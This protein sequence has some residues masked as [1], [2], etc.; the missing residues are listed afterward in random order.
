[1]KSCQ[2]CLFDSLKSLWECGFHLREGD[3]NT[4]LFH[5]HARHRRKNFI[6]KILDG[7]QVL[8]THEDKERVIYNFYN[9]LLGTSVHRERTINLDELNIASHH[10]IFPVWKSLFLKRFGEPSLICLLTKPQAPMVLQVSFIKCAGQL[11]K[12]TSWLRSQLS[13]AEDLE[14]SSSSIQPI[15]HFC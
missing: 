6:G 15:S 2:F 8:T 3:A 7:D 11:L 13:R 9:G 5:L 4:E 10:I 12:M 14:I 1:M